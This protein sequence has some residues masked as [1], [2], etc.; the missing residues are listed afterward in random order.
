VNIKNLKANLSSL[1][2]V[3]D[4]ME[5]STRVQEQDLA[6]TKAQMDIY[7]NNGQTAQYNAMVPAYNAAVDDYNAALAVYKEKIKEY[8]DLAA[9]FNQ[10]VKDF[11]QK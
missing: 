11:Y 7:F 2:L 5:T 9:Q 8:N 10:A 3:V 6:T 4:A 1:Q